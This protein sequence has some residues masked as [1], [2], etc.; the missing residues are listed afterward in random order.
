MDLILLKRVE[1]SLSFQYL[2][3]KYSLHRYWLKGFCL[4]DC[5]SSSLPFSV[6]HTH[7]VYFIE[8]S[9][10]H[11]MQKSNCDFNVKTIPLQ[12]VIVLFVWSIFMY[13][14]GD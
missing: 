10:E 6:G 12:N 7:K 1:L 3:R 2:G 5:S 8:D 4:Q 14:I 9:V 11:P 13:L